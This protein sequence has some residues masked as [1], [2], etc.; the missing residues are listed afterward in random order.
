MK[1]RP[2][3]S[4]KVKLNN[5]NIAPF[6]SF[7]QKG[8]FIEARAGS[9]IKDILC[10]QFQIKPQYLEDRIQTIFLDGKPVDEADKT[11]VAS[12]STLALSAAMPGLVGSTFRR[13]GPLAAFRSSITHNQDEGIARAE[14]SVRV[15]IKLFNLLVRELGPGFLKIGI[16]LHQKDII[17]IMENWTESF[18]SSILYGELNGQKI[19]SEQLCAINW[20]EGAE[21][22]LLS[23]L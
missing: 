12:G 20:P 19:S 14:G 21:D 15:R 3:R 18:A 13:G 9:T 2:Y 10:Q 4:L 1:T 5:P 11:T 8:F 7:L 16:F 17:E 23:I 6:F 22:I